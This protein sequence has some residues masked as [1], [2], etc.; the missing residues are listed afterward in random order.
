MVA[1]AAAQ[2][3]A[4]AHAA[5]AV[6]AGLPPPP[7]PP[8]PAASPAA[9]AWAN[10]APGTWDKQQARAAD[11]GQQQGWYDQNQGHGTDQNYDQ[12]AG[13]SQD[14]GYSQGKGKGYGYIADGGQQ[15][16]QGGKGFKGDVRRGG[17]FSKCQRLAELV[18]REDWDG[19]KSSAQDL[20]AGPGRF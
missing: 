15:Q 11:Q 7:M 10:Y 6:A 4:A 18:L 16:D 20:Y 12:G 2:A 13:S 17:W 14:Q 19:A 8:T 3:A 1:A 9:S 5:A